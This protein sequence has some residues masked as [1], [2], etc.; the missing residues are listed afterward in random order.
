M[1]DIFI[2]KHMSDV[3]V[4]R[5]AIVHA[6]GSNDIFANYLV[7]KGGTLMHLRYGSSR[8]TT[9]I[10]YTCTWNEAPSR[11]EEE[12]LPQIDAQLRQS[13]IAI[14]APD[15]EIRLQRIERKPSKNDFD[16][17]RFP[18]LKLRFG[19][20]RRGSNEHRRLISKQCPTT[21]QVDISF[22]EVVY[23]GEH[24]HI[25]SIDQSVRS[26]SAQEVFAEKIRAL[27]EQSIPGRGFTK[28]RR[29]DIYDLNFFLEQ[30]FIRTEHREEVLSMIIQKCELKG[31]SARREV[32]ADPD[33][34]LLCGKGWKT[35]HLEM[36]D[37]PE[38]DACYQNVQRYFESLPW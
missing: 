5:S 38:F 10:D 31:L 29:Q 32:F 3:D 17:M 6:F 11:F 20:A 12:L 34:K 36:S 2:K 23:S 30:K 15:W 28:E 16:A 27:I 37:L 18:A 25:E 7:L 9:D 35:L 13:S 22:R 1:S 8:Y 4:V 26:Y 19:Y 14:G 33:F 21:I 24:L